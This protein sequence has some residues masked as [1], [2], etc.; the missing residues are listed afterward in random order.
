MAP[1]RAML[2]ATRTLDGEPYS[3]TIVRALFPFNRFDGL[4]AI[5]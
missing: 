4:S 5:L 1:A 2:I 3:D